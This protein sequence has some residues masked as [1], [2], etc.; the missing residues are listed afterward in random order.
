MLK[1]YEKIEIRCQPIDPE[2][3]FTCRYLKKDPYE[4]K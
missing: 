3:S 1:E 2:R 4:M